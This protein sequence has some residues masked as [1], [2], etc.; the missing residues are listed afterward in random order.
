MQG[1]EMR[2][3]FHKHSS[4]FPEGRLNVDEYTRQCF[5]TKANNISYKTHTFL[6]ASTEVLQNVFERN[7]Y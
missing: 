5:F 2:T 1:H 6:N 3:M 7:S 4:N